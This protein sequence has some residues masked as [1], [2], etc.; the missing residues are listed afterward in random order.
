M[1]ELGPPPGRRGAGGSRLWWHCPFHEDKNP[2]L[3]IEPGRRYWKCFGCGAKG[4]AVSLVMLLRRVPFLEALGVV[5]EG[6]PF[7]SET[8]TGWRH[9]YTVS[10]PPPEPPPPVEA[11]GPTGWGAV[12]ARLIV[13]TAAELLWTDDG[14]EALEYLRGRG[15]D[16]E[17]I[18]RAG[19]G[20]VPF[21]MVRTKDGRR[22]FS[23]SGWV[24]P[25]FDGGAVAA[26]KIRQPDGREPRYLEAY[27]D[28]PLFYP[29]P[30]LAPLRRWADIAIV[31]GEFDALL[32][33]QELAGLA[34][35]ITTGSASSRP[36]LNLRS[37]LAQARR[38]F[39][40]TDADAAGDAC[41]AAWPER[42]IR[43]RPPDGHKDW[44]DARR[45]G[46]DLRA[47]WVERALC[48]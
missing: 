22:A 31:E 34:T 35:V 45:A 15:L 38:L 14:A 7:A 1:R 5:L 47:W 3:L 13:D 9:C 41:C 21:V 8:G 29:G 25:W 44:T 12:E 6:T 17:T 32:L 48:E 43:V 2:S 46:I 20:W 4:D 16:D 33:G 24:I 27:R 23:A 10:A 18:R 19:L 40:A 26:V 30:R 42:A 28:R 37:A 39:L 36:S 11:V